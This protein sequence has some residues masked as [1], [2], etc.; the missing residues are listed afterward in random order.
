M[1]LH[2]VLDWPGTHNV[3]NACVSQSVARL[4]YTSTIDV[5][6][7]FSDLVDADESAP[8][9]DEFLFPGYPETKYRAETAVINADQTPLTGSK[10]KC[11]YSFMLLIDFLL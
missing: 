6:V 2:N 1:V 11:L 10:D 9:P 4:V 5:V 8:I 7:G 3:I